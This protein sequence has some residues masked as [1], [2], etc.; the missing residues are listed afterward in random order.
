MNT[1]PDLVSIFESV[2]TSIPS[3]LGWL[4]YVS[5]V[6][7]AVA[8]AACLFQKLACRKVSAR[9]IYV[10]WILVCLR[11]VLVWA[12]ESPTSFLNFFERPSET[13]SCQPFEFEED[14]KRVTEGLSF[15]LSLI[16][17]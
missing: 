17:I 2:S 12:P 5:I 9:L 7:S 6:A 13:T 10:V 14:A 11:F 15:D 3:W 4:L 1:V 16:H 8:L